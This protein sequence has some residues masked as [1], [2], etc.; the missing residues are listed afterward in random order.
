MQNGLTA[1]MLAVKS[2]R[3]GPGTIETVKYLV[4]KKT[5]DATDA[6]SYIIGFHLG[7]WGRSP[8]LIYFR[9]LD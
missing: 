3:T 1:L 9:P 6:V 8:P 7:D 4:D 5:A 2:D